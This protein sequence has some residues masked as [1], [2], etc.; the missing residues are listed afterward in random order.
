MKTPLLH[1][2]PGGHPA[3]ALLLTA[4]LTGCAAGPDYQAPGPLADNALPHPAPAVQNSASETA[5]GAAQTWRADMDLEAPWWQQLGSPGLDALIAEALQASPTLAAAQAQLRQA[6]ELQGAQERATQLP[7]VDLGVGSGRQHISPSAQ[8]LPGDGRTFSLHSASVGVQYQLDL[9]GGNRRALEALAARTDYRRYQLAGARLDLAARLASTAITQARIAAQAEALEAIARNQEAQSALARERVRLGQAMPADEQA[10]QAALE[11][12]R[13]SILQLRKQ[14]VQ[15]GHLLAV[16]AGRTPG[17]APLPAFTL[18]DFTLPAALPQVLPSELVRQRPDIQAAEALV[19]A[20]SADHGVAVARMY[21]QLRLSA[22][23]GSQ[24]LTAGALF[25][26]GS[27]VW[28]LIAQLTQPLFDPALPAQQRAAL[29]ALDAAAAQYQAVVLDALRSVADALHSAQAD[30]QVL[31]ALV[32]A[33]AAAQASLQA[34]QHQLHLGAASYL[35]WLVA[36]QQALQ[37]RS[38]L[39]AAQAQ[40]LADSAALFQAVGAG[41]RFAMPM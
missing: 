12:T 16:L 11:Q 7:R 21:P 3:W 2:L 5:F 13:A 40:R 33:D 39:V 28:G 29:A 36:E 14:A 23:L 20:A 4:L 26:G 1:R 9:S 24:A 22:S 17:E 15:S 34:T 27:A 19:Q 10:L 18:H 32:R 37:L 35:Q 30:A 6:Q 38:S 8:G 31:G 25:G 41:G